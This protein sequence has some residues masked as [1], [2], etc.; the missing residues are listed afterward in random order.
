MIRS[1]RLWCRGR[2]DGAGEGVST[3]GYTAGTLAIPM[4]FLVASLV[5]AVAV[6]LL[7][8]WAWLR[9]TL[10]V[11]TVISIVAGANW[12]AGRVVHPHL[13]TSDALTLRSGRDTVLSVDRSRIVRAVPTRRF[14]HTT[15]GIHGDRLYLPG[16]DGTVIDIDFDAP[17]GVEH[18]TRMVTG[19]S[20]HVD[21]PRDLCARLS[22]QG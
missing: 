15:S 12:F 10:L 3:F 6:H 21:A 13:V 14:E 16:P 7:V 17:V 20:L 2:V 19:V 18:E 22:M 11:I 4:A 8:P 5:E 9:A 1:L